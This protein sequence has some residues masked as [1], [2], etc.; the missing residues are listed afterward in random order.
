MNQE[1]RPLLLVQALSPRECVHIAVPCAYW[2]GAAREQQRWLLASCGVGSGVD[3]TAG[4]AAQRRQ[5]R[6]KMRKH[7]AAFLQQA[8]QQR[9]RVWHELA[10]RTAELCQAAHP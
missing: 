10:L 6:A 1:R 3:V 8:R 2:V 7:R 5:Q 4:T 9:E